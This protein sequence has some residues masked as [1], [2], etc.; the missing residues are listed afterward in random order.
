[1]K[2]LTATG[3]IRRLHRCEVDT[4]GCVHPLVDV[5]P[6]ACA[7]VER[8]GYEVKDDLSGGSWGVFNYLITSEARTY[9]AAIY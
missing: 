6:S 3:H 4:R 5:G 1:V 2:N 8:A 9:L 7:T